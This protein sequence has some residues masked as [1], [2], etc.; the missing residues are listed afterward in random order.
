MSKRPNVVFIL[1]DDQGSWAMGCGGTKSL[2]T[3]NLDRLAGEGVRFENFFCASPVCSPARASILTGKIPSGHGV[4]DWIRS[5]NLDRASLEKRGIEST[6]GGYAAEDKPV[7]YLRGQTAYTDLLAEAGYTCALSGK[8][9]L[10]DSLNP[11]HG[12]KYWYTIGRGGCE[13]YRPDMVENGAVKVEKGRYVTD[14]IT[15]KALVFLD[16]LAEGDSP[17]YLGVHYTAPH[18]PWDAEHHPADLITMYDRCDFSG[19]PDVPDH[20]WSI[21]NKNVMGKSRHANLRGYFAAITAMDK[22]IG[23]LLG[24]LKEKGLRENTIVIFCSDNGMNM[25]H[26][27]IWGKGNGTFPQNMY[28]TSVKVPFIFSWPSTGKAGRI[29]NGMASAY[30]IFPTFVELLDLD[31]SA[32]IGLPGKSFLSLLEGGGEID[33]GDGGARD[34][35]VF[36]EYGPVRMIRTQN[37]KYIHRYPYGPNEF[38]NLTEDPGEEQNC[39]DNGMYAG[40]IKE[41][42]GR[43]ERWF[44]RYADPLIDGTR[45]EVSGKGQ[46]CL[47]GVYANKAA[48]YAANDRA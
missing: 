38:Y 40:E 41:L 32:L 21:Y 23:R 13:Y 37:R 45:E 30:D 3:P 27:G 19:I 9:H 48:K 29:C 31:T 6:Y 8:W 35:V 10:G 12:F 16:K 22:G 1:S 4:H 47:A 24:A 43:M 36:D 15:D 7:Q 46:L 17:F 44:L 28:D 20:P 14:L 5:G 26:H 2:D 42:R 33:R 25:G 34:V 18:S 11:Q 39:A